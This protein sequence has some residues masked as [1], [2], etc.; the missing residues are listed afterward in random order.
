MDGYTL[1]WLKLQQNNV[2][3]TYSLDLLDLSGLLG[4]VGKLAPSILS[5]AEAL[6][7]ATGLLGPVESVVG[8]IG[9]LFPSST[10]S[11]NGTSPTMTSTAKG[12]QTT[13]EGVSSALSSSVKGSTSSPTS[14]SGDLLNLPLPTLSL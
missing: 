8:V 2:P 12:R 13:T 3:T 11:H 14:S 7:S 4:D 9:G 6:P 10:S 1:P 5:I